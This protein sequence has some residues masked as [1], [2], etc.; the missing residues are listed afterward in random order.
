MR[1][2]NYGLCTFYV[3]MNHFEAHLMIS[4]GVLDSKVLR[5]AIQFEYFFI[6]M[7]IRRN[8]ECNIRNFRQF[9]F[10]MSHD[11]PAFKV[12]VFTSDFRFW[13]GVNEYY[14]VDILTQIL[15]TL[16]PSITYQF[17]KKYQFV[18]DGFSLVWV[19]M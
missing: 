6:I 4:S 11:V 1:L 18:V 7:I 9:L 14:V 3:K 13:I 10:G 16:L 19:I 8:G 12:H 15:L 17:C 5:M 2:T